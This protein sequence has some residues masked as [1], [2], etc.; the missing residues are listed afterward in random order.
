MH[1]VKHGSKLSWAIKV[2][3]NSLGVYLGTFKE[4][5]KEILTCCK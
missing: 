3:D 4:K 1:E 2:L 5:S